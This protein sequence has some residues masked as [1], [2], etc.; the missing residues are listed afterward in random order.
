MLAWALD[1]IPG[2]EGDCPAGEG[3]ANGRLASGRFKSGPAFLRTVEK[4]KSLIHFCEYGHG[5]HRLIPVCWVVT[6]NDFLACLADMPSDK[7]SFLQQPR[8]AGLNFLVIGDVHY[9]LSVL[10]CSYVKSRLREWEI[11]WIWKYLNTKILP[12]MVHNFAEQSTDTCRSSNRGLFHSS[13]KRT[14]F[15]WNNRICKVFPWKQ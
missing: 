14:R 4:G 9:I 8:T 15:C 10:T 11:E 2:G 3:F 1:V 13:K 12:I 5:T 6:G 7:T